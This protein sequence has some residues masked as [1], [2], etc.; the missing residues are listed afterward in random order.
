MYVKE[1]RW[2]LKS[3]YSV[4]IPSPFNILLG[5]S[6]YPKLDSTCKFLVIFLK[7]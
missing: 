7:I 6:I 2:C 4:G 1:T 3:A 5:Y